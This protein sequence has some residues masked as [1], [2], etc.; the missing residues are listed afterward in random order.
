M[1]PFRLLA[2]L[3][4]TLGLI[5]SAPAHAT[6]KEATEKIVREYLMEHPEV[7]IDA[8]RVYQ[9]REEAKQAAAN[10]DLLANLKTGIGRDD[11]I[12]HTGNKDGDVVIIEF[13]DYNCGFC[14]RVLPTIQTLLKEDTNIRYVFLELPILAPTSE[15]AARAALATWKIAPE[16]YMDL[17]TAIMTSKGGLSDDKIMMLVEKTGLDK[18][19]IEQEM[20]SDAI[21]MALESNHLLARALGVN[22]TPGFVIGDKLVPGAIS[23]EEMNELVNKARS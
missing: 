12:P 17:H 7:I 14:K 13:F 21:S 1:T 15:T 22:G 10:K 3:I 5:P 18:A 2:F 8:I 11:S 23:L 19:V 20:K 9:Q 4:V 6:D 16:K